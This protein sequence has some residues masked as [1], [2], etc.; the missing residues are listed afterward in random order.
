MK[1]L[2]VLMTFLAVS[3]GAQADVIPVATSFLIWCSIKGLPATF[4]N[5][6]G[7]VSVSGRIRSPRPAANIIAFIIALPST[8]YLVP[9]SLSF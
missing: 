7:Q 8:S 3:F 4:N 9:V 5:G 1:G 2:I 6:L